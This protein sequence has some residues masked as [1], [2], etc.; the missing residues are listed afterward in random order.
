MFYGREMGA[1]CRRISKRST[2]FGVHIP[3]AEGRKVDA[4]RRDLQ[5]ILGKQN[6]MRTPQER[7]AALP[8][9]VAVAVKW[10]LDSASAEQGPVG[11]VFFER[12]IKAATDEIRWRDYPL[13]AQNSIDTI[14]ATIQAELRIQVERLNFVK[15]ALNVVQGLQN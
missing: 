4:I 11:K 7:D 15:R 10:I 5:G 2:D 13:E 9:E 6:L 14:R 8:G 3:S 1:T 12:H